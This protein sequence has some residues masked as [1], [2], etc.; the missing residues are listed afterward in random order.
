M[1]FDNNRDTYWNSDYAPQW[2]EKDLGA[3]VGLASI[4]LIVAQTP[5]GAT[6]HEVWV[7]NEPIG[8]DRS[9]A[10]LA[11]TFKGETADQQALRFDFPKDLSARY[12]QIFTTQSPSW[13]GWREVDIQ[14]RKPGQVQGTPKP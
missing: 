8:H 6:I 10:K 2:I 4:E 7:S 13:I 5:A 1:A 12:V 14:V 9:K 11:H 3:V